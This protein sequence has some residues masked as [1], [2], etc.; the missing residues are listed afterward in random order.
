MTRSSTGRLRLAVPV[1]LAVALGSIHAAPAA[2]PQLPQLPHV[3]A[4]DAP[5]YPDYYALALSH[6][7]LADDPQWR[8]LHLSQAPGRAQPAV[9][10]LP[11]QTQ[12][13]GFAPVFRA[14]LGARL[15][16]E[17]ERRHVDASRQTDIVDWRGPFV[18]RTDEATLT[19]FAGEHPGAT[20]L[21]L[22]L[23]HDVDGHALVTLGRTDAGKARLARRR[24]EIPDDEAS[25]LELLAG[26]LPG[27]LAELGLGEARAAA[28]V[29]P[30][31][32]GAC[33]SADWTLRELPAD[34]AP[35]AAA[36]QAL[37]MGSLIPDH[38]SLEVMNPQ[39]SAPDRLAWLAR[40]WVEADAVSA[41]R[42]PMRP[43]AALAAL[44]LRWPR[45]RPAL[46]VETLVGE[47]D[48]VVGPLARMLWT[49][50]QA[51]TSPDASRSGATER[52]L[53]PALAGLP[54][55]AAAAVTE[56][57][58][59]TL[60][61]HTVDLCALELAV[62]TL[63]PP[64]GCEDAAQESPRGGAPATRH[65]QQ[66]LDN[67]RLAAGWRALYVEGHM[68]GS[69]PGLADAL[70]QMPR[71]IATHPTTRL[72][73]FAVHAYE[74]RVD[75]LDAH[76]ARSRERVLDYAQAHATLQRLDMIALR[77]PASEDLLGN[78]TADPAIAHALDDLLRVGDVAGGDLWGALE[79]PV[80][81]G[82]P[83]TALLADGSYQQAQWRPN[84]PVGVGIEIARASAASAPPRPTPILPTRAMPRPRF[85]IRQMPALA[86]RDELAR[87]LQA[88]P[89]DMD[90]RVA[91]ALVE[92]KRGTPIAEV[93][94]LLDARPRS[95]RPDDAL[96]EG[97]ELS[98][99][100]HLFFFGGESAAASDYYRAA[101]ATRTYSDADL[102]SRVRVA[103]IAGDVRAAMAAGHQRSE[104]YG[105]EWAAG[106]EAG[107]R[108]MLGQRDQAWA[109]ILPRAQ[110]ST[111]GGLWR[112]AT[113]GHRA[114]GTP[115][116]ALPDW[117][118]RNRLDSAL[119]NY[120]DGIVRAWMR[121]Y[122]I[123]DRLPSEADIALL[124]MKPR[125]P[126]PGLWANG[127]AVIKASIDGQPAR[128]V[129]SLDEDMQLT[130]GDD[131][132]LLLPFFAWATWNAS[133]G[134]DPLLDQVRKVPL[135]A[136]FPFVLSKAMVLAAD[137]QRDEALRFLNAARWELG[138]GGSV[139]AFGD[140][141]RTAPYDFVLASWLM[142]RKTGDRAYA[143]PGLAV[144]RGYQHVVQ[145]MGWPYAAEALLGQDAKA[146]EIAACRARK[147]DPGSMMLRE[148]GLHPDP[149]GAACRTATA[150]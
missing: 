114:A 93:R 79:I 98:A 142:W 115:L 119:P 121:Q 137:G 52:H 81:G 32:S 57:A 64:A 123:L 94:R 97:E 62:A 124:G 75:G 53:Q 100:A 144:A 99:A 40:A 131:H 66:L 63:R 31:R 110:T 12:A 120:G 35:V 138:R 77:H 33:E 117:L 7:T 108:F 141:L 106:D 85:D 39:P 149:A 15:D 20:L 146:R 36:C 44:Q 105:G 92:L 147:L 136:A 17:L 54:P 50:E 14:L 22:Y 24:L 143:A 6:T 104:R 83:S 9:I 109:L 13:Y 107:Y 65:Q 38:L 129:P 68:R 132:L 113:A 101:A 111:E 49:P 28:P 19:A 116:A 61:F 48:P 43:V 21:A 45:G 90:T 73:R 29:A 41:Q 46:E 74:K 59:L 4:P 84:P 42:P 103:A 51:R 134:K 27:L 26:A 71:R 16:L 60:D 70:R 102:V 150:W 89:Y 118:A 25:A 122:A 112:G 67:W 72:I 10:V 88:A 56:L 47:R 34:A 18:R 3:A 78:E 11:V 135:E 23:G 76:L 148:S 30:G 125:D 140:P 139:H 145:F 80:R 1:L 96:R 133:G 37:L 8:A 55:F 95:M 128:G 130:T 127:L 126:K 58:W 87:A 5:L 2:A 82:K 86:P 91:L 69:A